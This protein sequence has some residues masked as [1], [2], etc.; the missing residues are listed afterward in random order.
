PQ[1]LSVG[2]VRR[3]L[4]LAFSSISSSGRAGGSG[5]YDAPMTNSLHESFQAATEEKIGSDR[6]FGFIFVAVFGVVGLWPLLKGYEPRWWALAVGAAFG[7]LAVLAPRLLRPLNRAWMAFG[8][9]L[10]S[11][12][13]PI[14]I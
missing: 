6:S 11:I 13:S 4:S 12:V 9:L 5:I 14:V 7:L 8:R 3:P 1:S 2:C 10:H